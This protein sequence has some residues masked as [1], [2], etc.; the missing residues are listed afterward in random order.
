M[1]TENLQID[2]NIIMYA[3][4]MIFRNHSFGLKSDVPE[5]NTK[6]CNAIMS[7]GFFLKKNILIL[8]SFKIEN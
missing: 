1:T 7:R 6:L 2:R 4:T 8:R 3:Y 5:K